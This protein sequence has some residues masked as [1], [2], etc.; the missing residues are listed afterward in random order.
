[1]SKLSCFG[2]FQTKAICLPSGEN[3]GVLR[4]PKSLASG[5]TSKPDR[6]VGV[7]TKIDQSQ[8]APLRT[9]IPAA[10]SRATLMRTFRRPAS[11]LTSGG[12]ASGVLSSAVLAP[13]S[14]SASGRLLDAT[15][16]TGGSGVASAG[17][18]VP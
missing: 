15:G 6:T 4:L 3:A 12:L 10:T 7:F 9:T 5:T 2:P 17:D 8:T 13:A 1:M 11:V 16:A 14:G 18:A